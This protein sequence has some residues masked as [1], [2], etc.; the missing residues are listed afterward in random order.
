MPKIGLITSISKNSTGWKGESTEED[1]SSSKFDFVKINGKAHESLNFGYPKYPP[2]S[3]GTYIGYAPAFN[4]KV[5]EP[6]IKIIFL[7]SLFAVN[8]HF[9]YYALIAGKLDIAAEKNVRCPDSGIEP[10]HGCYDKS[11]RLPPMVVSGKVRT[12]MHEYLGQ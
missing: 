9:F 6:N 1:L 11:K 12:F 10:I 3:D 4:K 5:R 7:I 8:A 2:E